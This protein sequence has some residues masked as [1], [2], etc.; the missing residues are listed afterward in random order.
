VFSAQRTS[1]VIG[2]KIAGDSGELLRF[3]SGI[4]VITTVDSLQA[5]ARQIDVQT[6]HGS[7][8]AFFSRT[9]TNAFPDGKAFEG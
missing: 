1:L 9:K 5:I 3:A 2:P 8:H 6:A 7:Q 4:E